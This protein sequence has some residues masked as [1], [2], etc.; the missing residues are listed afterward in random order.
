MKADNEV[1]NNP[2]NLIIKC[3]YNLHVN[4]QGAS[5]LRT[6]VI[7]FELKGTRNLLK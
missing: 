1:P 7:Y 6:L 5:K 4:Q 3:L 2:V